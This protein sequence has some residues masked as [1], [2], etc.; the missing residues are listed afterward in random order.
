VTDWEFA[1]PRNSVEAIVQFVEA[2]P[3]AR[4]VL[5]D[6]LREHEDVLPHILMADLRRLFVELVEA[7]REDDV[8]RFLAGVE[9]LAASPAESIRN[10]VDV[11]FIED[12]VLGDR[13]EK[14]ALQSVR[15][16]LGPA[17]A[18]QLVATE[19]ARGAAG[20]ES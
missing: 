12:L 19:R 2:L 6:H 17:T 13:H 7:G 3:F 5:E 10:V 15:S 14:R 8:T 9:T 18:A 11:S 4:D 20:A 16:L 1:R